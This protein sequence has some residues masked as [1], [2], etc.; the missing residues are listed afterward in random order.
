[1]FWLPTLTWIAGVA[2][3]H[4]ARIP[5]SCATIFRRA[6]V[7]PC[8]TSCAWPRHRHHALITQVIYMPCRLSKGDRAGWYIPGSA[9]WLS[10]LQP[11]VAHQL[12]CAPAACM[13]PAE[14]HP[15][16]A[17]SAA[18]AGSAQTLTRSAGTA[19]NCPMAPAARPMPI[20]AMVARSGLSA[21]GLAEL[22]RDS[23]TWN[24][25]EGTGTGSQQSSILVLDG[26]LAGSGRLRQAYHD[27]GACEQEEGRKGGGGGPHHVSRQDSGKETA[28]ASGTALRMQTD[29][30]FTS[31]APLY[32][33]CRATAG[34][35]PA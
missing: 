18:C 5:P 17:G 9:D 8:H 13:A 24:H 14:V 31:C 33:M 12:A 15:P 16:A 23:N 19:T 2:P 22:R 6:S 4:S 20:L 11:P 28:G 3:L 34:L 1:M 27:P 25:A 30:C 10:C 26:W 35:T 29:D 7:M 32:G 21:E